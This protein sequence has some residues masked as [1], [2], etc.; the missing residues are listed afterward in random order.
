MIG[1]RL[2]SPRTGSSVIPWSE[3]LRSSFLRGKHAASIR[4]AIDTTNVQNETSFETPAGSPQM[5]YDSDASRILHKARLVK[6][7]K[8]FRD[9]EIWGA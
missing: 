2:H 4:D 9:K 3:K 1:H 8:K 6:Y 7:L 5:S